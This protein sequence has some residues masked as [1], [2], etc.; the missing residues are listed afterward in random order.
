MKKNNN[1][2]D[3]SNKEEIKN[4][5]EDSDKL[6]PG[7]DGNLDLEESPQ[8]YSSTN[9]LIYDDFLFQCRKKLILSRLKKKKKLFFLKKAQNLKNQDKDCLGLQESLPEDKKKNS[10]KIWK[11]MQL[12]REKLNEDFSFVEKF[13]KLMN[14]QKLSTDIDIK[15][16]EKNAELSNH[17]QE[18]LRK[19]LNFFQEK[20][21]SA[22]NG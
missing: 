16:L 9:Y 14:D 21:W 18:Q 3:L 13:V 10:Q 7:N 5:F 1:N 20:F 8:N 6:N 2:K 22:E 17:F 4:C 15:K 19:M 11:K 12:V